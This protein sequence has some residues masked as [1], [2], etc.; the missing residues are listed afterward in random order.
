[1]QIYQKS[2]ENADEPAWICG[3]WN[4]SPLEIGAGFRTEVGPHE[5]RHYH[6]YREYFV[7]LDGVADLEVDGRHIAL[8][9]GMVVMIEAGEWHHI[10]A[11]Q[12]PGA[13]WVVIKERS[14]PNT[15]YIA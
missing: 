8:R 3:Y 2:V 7:V 14:A 11:V 1:M 5:V 13:R 10:T 12:A 9:A 4:G 15:K 6:P